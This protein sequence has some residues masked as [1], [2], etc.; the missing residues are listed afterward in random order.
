[1]DK[2]FK[3][4]ISIILGI[5][6]LIFLIF[7]PTILI[8]GMV[9]SVKLGV[10]IKNAGENYNKQPPPIATIEPI[11]KELFFHFYPGSKTYSL[12]ATEQDLEC[13]DCKEKANREPPAQV[14]AEASASGAVIF[15]SVCPDSAAACNYAF[16]LAR[17]AKQKNLS[18]ALSYDGCLSTEI[19]KKI[20]P[21]F[22]AV[23]IELGNLQNNYCQKITGTPV[24]AA[25]ENIK[26]VVGA[27]K[28]LEISYVLNPAN[29]AD[30]EINKFLAALKENVGAE[31]IIHFSGAAN[32][33]QAVSMEIIKHARD[34]ALNT[35]FKYAYT[36]GINYPEGENTYCADGSIALQRQNYYLIKNNLKDGVCSD[37]SVIPGIW[38]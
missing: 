37:G 3:K 18:T 38:Q 25:L 33:G 27:N 19:L 9:Q 14:I 6:F 17:L 21:A 24:A 32:E 8:E 2:R 34:L 20:I 13:T 11:E 16:E 31:A 12:A 5:L 35:G 36:G 30:E 22:D 26:A 28:H 15:S 1:M 23:K 4:I 10:K 29:A 7:L